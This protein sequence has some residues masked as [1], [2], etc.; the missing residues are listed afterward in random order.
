LITELANFVQ[1]KETEEFDFE[2]LVGSEKSYWR[3]R[4]STI[5]LRVLTC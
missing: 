3:G 4:L 2:R 5:D 1:E